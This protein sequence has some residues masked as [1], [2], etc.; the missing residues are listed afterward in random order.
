M[1]KLR[2]MTL[3][4]GLLALPLTPALAQDGPPPCSEAPD[5]DFDFWL[6]TWSVASTDGTP[7]GHN[8]IRKEEAGCLIIESWTSVQGTTGQS[9]NFYDPGRETW[10]Q[11]W[12]SP[13]ATID[14]AG[15]LDGNGDMVLEGEIAYRNGR[16]APFRGRWVANEDGTVTQ[17]FHELNAETGE[18]MD[19][20]TGIYS[21]AA[22]GRAEPDGEAADPA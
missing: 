6:G 9:Y 1:M 10:R 11:V 16:V 12:V 22:E 5:T 19:W 14:Y 13:G 21:P 20:F 4:C 8:L 3:I 7:A 2:A 15:G 17:I 18:W